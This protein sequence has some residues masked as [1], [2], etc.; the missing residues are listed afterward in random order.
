[1]KM[2]THNGQQLLTG[3]H[4]CC[5]LMVVSLG[6]TA[7]ILLHLTDILTKLSAIAPTLAVR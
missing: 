4:T 6:L 2:L 5:V 7:L 1:M 3:Q